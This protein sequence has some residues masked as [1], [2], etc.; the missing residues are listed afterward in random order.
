MSDFVLRAQEP[1]VIEDSRAL[2]GWKCGMFKWPPTVAIC[3]EHHGPDASGYSLGA[4]S[5]A[6]FCSARATSDFRPLP[7]A[8]SFCCRRKFN[9]AASSSARS[10]F[11][12]AAWAASVAPASVTSA[13]DRSALEISPAAS[14]YSNCTTSCLACASRAF[15]RS[16]CRR[17]TRNAR[18][19]TSTF[20]STPILKRRSAPAA[21]FLARSN[22]F[23]RRSGSRFDAGF[24]AVIASGNGSFERFGINSGGST[25]NESSE[26]CFGKSCAARAAARQRN[27]HENP[28]GRTIRQ[29]YHGNIGRIEVNL[30][31]S[32]TT[33]LQGAVVCLRS[34]SIEQSRVRRNFN[35]RVDRGRQAIRLSGRRGSGLSN[36]RDGCLP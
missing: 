18:C 19:S 5:S 22:S 13:C 24:P 36:S 8:M 11:S 15:S 2:T 12:A 20:A 9:S 27:A 16:D 31:A 35:P 17:T 7:N 26:S 21:L 30:S 23:S 33:F 6:S 14:R 29:H 1:D 10:R 28:D 32:H 4:F 3:R 34:R 25:S